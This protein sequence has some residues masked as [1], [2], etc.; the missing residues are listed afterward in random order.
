MI[1]DWKIPERG[2]SLFSFIGLIN[3]Y[4]KYAPY[5]G[6]RLKPLR[7]LLK[8]YYRKTI[9]MIVWTPDLISPFEELKVTITSSPVLGRFNP[10]NPT[11]LKTDWSAEGTEWIL[12][13]P[14]D[15]IESTKSTKAL[16]KCSE[17]TFNLSEDGARLHPVRFGS[18]AFTYFERKYHS[19]VGEAASGRWEISQ[20]RHYLWGN[21]FWWM[22]DCAAIKEILEYEGSISQICR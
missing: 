20:N 17:C 22:C 16:L 10:L 5:I 15:D 2:E 11:F 4:H 3:F 6:I 1:D 13:Q 12:M 7:K 21:K 8:Q 19:F 18:R 14:E 9:P